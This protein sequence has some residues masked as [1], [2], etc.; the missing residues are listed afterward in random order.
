MEAF[1]VVGKRNFVFEKPHE[2]YPELVRMLYANISWKDGMIISEV[3]KPPITMSF[4]DFDQVSNLPF[5]EED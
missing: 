4:E 2:R 3:K 5:I 1:N